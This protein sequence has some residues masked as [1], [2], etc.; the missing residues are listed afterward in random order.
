[1]TPGDDDGALQERFAALRTDETRTAPSFV[2]VRARLPVRRRH[3][4]NRAFVLAAAAAALVIGL[5]IPWPDGARV[6]EEG[7]PTSIT[8]WR[9]PTAFLLQSPGAPL[10]QASPA[11]GERWVMVP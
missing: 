10:L 1:M 9:S 3:G 2:N 11:V 5:L 8:E 4:R 7:E 6:P